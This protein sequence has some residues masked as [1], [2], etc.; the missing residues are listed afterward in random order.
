VG[1]IIANRL[2]A[3]QVRKACEVLTD[4]DYGVCRHRRYYQ[5]AGITIQLQS[6]IPI[7]DQ[8]FE[9][10]L[11]KFEVAEPGSDIIS[12]SLHFLLPDLQCINLGKEVY[13]RPPWVI[14]RQ[15]K[16]WIYLGIAPKQNNIGAQFLAVFNDD[17]S[18]GAIYANRKD[19][20]LK[21]QLSSLTLFPTDQ[22]LLACILADRNACIFH[23]AAIIMNKRGLLFL[24]DSEAGKTTIAAMLESKAEII[25]D[26][27]NIVRRWPEGFRIHGTWM[28]SK[29][30]VVSSSSGPLN[31]IMF[32]RKSNQNCINP[33]SNR[34]EITRNLLKYVVKSLVTADWW[35]KTIDL[36]KSMS[37]ELPCYELEFDR[38]GSIADELEELVD[39]LTFLGNDL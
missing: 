29:I 15:D 21:G 35:N 14:Y 5:I 1:N 18:L 39:R 31:A 10:E 33:I 38:T 26:E 37:N 27:R 28:H 20:F 30:P 12:I 9:L 6:D 8:T 2:I 11:K 13:R 22:I 23:S 19:Q 7:S 17:H 4:K 24:G 32:L 25:C 16:S 34:G 36:M 3:P